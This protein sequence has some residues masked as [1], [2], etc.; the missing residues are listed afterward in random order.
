M[1]W[2]IKLATWLLKDAAIDVSAGETIIFYDNQRVDYEV[3]SEILPQYSQIHL[4]A[5]KPQQKSLKDCV[6]AISLPSA[7]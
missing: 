7:R 4:V 1:N 2:R 3:L 5:C 6:F